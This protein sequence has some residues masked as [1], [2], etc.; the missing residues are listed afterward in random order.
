MNSAFTDLESGRQAVDQGADVLDRPFHPVPQ[1]PLVVI[2][3]TQ[4]GSVPF[5]T[6]SI[7]ARIRVASD[8]PDGAGVAAK[9]DCRKRNTMG[10][11]PSNRIGRRPVKGAAWLWDCRRRQREQSELF[12]IV[13]SLAEFQ[14]RPEISCMNCDGAQIDHSLVVWLRG[15]N[16]NS[17]AL[18]R[19]AEWIGK[20]GEP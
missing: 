19:R 20:K 1:N 13:V 16:P 2:D 12:F 6:R 7:A 14:H 17:S 3:E 11:L 5:T 18:D 10:T 8:L 4:A 9:M 15:Y